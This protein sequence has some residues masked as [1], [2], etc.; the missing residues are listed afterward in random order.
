[1]HVNRLPQSLT[2]A[3]LRRAFA[4]VYDSVVDATICYSRDG[5]RR[6]I[7]GFVYFSDTQQAKEAVQHGTLQVDHKTIAINPDTT[8][9]TQEHKESVRKSTSI[10]GE[11]WT[12]YQ[13]FEV[14]L[15]TGRCTRKY[16]NPITNS[17]VVD[18]QFRP[19][20]YNGDRD[21]TASWL[22]SVTIR[23][24]VRLQ[25]AEIKSLYANITRRGA[26]GAGGADKHGPDHD[27][28]MRIVRRMRREF[29][30][31]TL[32]TSHSGNEED[33]SD[34]QKRQEEL[35]GTTTSDLVERAI[36]Q[37]LDVQTILKLY[38]S[39]TSATA[40]GDE[41]RAKTVKAELVIKMLAQ[42]LRRRSSTEFE[43]YVAAW[44][45]EWQNDH[46]NEVKRWGERLKAPKNEWNAAKDQA[47]KDAVMWPVRTYSEGYRCHCSTRS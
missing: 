27:G 17:M 21:L 45:C 15:Q 31:G 16:R 28:V 3:S 32:V 14:E 13:A 44:L 30:P 5:S 22:T 29:L 40:Q 36:E 33:D 34:Q 38:L 43:Q 46:K 10:I 41:E 42:P 23:D 6:K 37:R 39:S 7:F 19:T 8:E 9:K 20:T 11:I 2:E 35:M 26:A 12:Q 18:P 25:C 1:M 4:Q 24:T 47:A